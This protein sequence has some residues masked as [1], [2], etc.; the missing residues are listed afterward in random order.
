M[1]KTRKLHGHTNSLEHYV[2]STFNMIS[3]YMD[4][5]DYKI[6]WIYKIRINSRKHR[7]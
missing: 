7:N 3:L 1:D 4:S 5:K 6:I 2:R